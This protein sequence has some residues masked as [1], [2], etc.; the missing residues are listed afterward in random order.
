MPGSLIPNQFDCFDIYNTISNLAPS[1]PHVSDTKRLISVRAT[2]EHPNG[3]RKP[4]TPA[5]FD[6]AIIIEDE[7]VYKEGEIEGM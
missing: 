5:R 2:P 4:P 6:T 1:K 7:E 3:P